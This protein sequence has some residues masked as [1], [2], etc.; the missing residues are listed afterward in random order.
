MYKH[1]TLEI[2]DPQVLIMTI[3]RPKALNALNTEV[4]D[5]LDDFFARS[6]KQY[7]SLRAVIITGSGEKAFVAGADISGFKNLNEATALQLSLD[8][9][10]VFDSIENFH[11]PVIAAINGY[12][13]GGGL[14]L[15]MSCHLRT[16]SDNARFG[17]PELSLGLIPGYT[18][19]QRLIQ[20]V[21]KGRALHMM[22]TGKMIN[23][24]ESQSFGLSN[25]VCSK[26]TLLEETVLLVKKIIKNGPL[27]IEETIKCVNAFFDADSDGDQYESEQFAR[28]MVSA[29]GREGSLAFLE[30][31]KANFIGK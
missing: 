17:L 12:A 1:L 14:E 2:E 10:K 29:D 22:L 28:L 25:L 19:T 5:E 26:E 9:K 4:I 13:L 6:Y 30:K 11:L 31:R 3:N 27:A 23:A 20:L 8:G 15:A 16:A 21:G 7:E 18:G 24:D